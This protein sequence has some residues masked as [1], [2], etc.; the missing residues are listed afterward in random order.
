MKLPKQQH[1]YSNVEVRG[2]RRSTTLRAMI[3]SGAS[4]TFINS[5]IVQLHHI[6]KE[7]LEET[8]V[9]HNIDQT[10]NAGG[11][12]TH[13]APLTLI[14][15][16]HLERIQFLMA[17]IGNDDIILGIDWLDKHNPDI[18]WRKRTIEFRRCNCHRKGV[19]S[20]I[21]LVPD[22]PM[23]IETRCP[24]ADTIIVAAVKNFAQQFADKA[25]EGKKEKTYEELVPTWIR[26]Y[27]DVFSD[28]NATRLPEHTL[29]DHEINLREGFKPRTGK[30]TL[31]LQN[32]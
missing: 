32:R 23:D 26:D 11:Y 13:Y 9:L 24:R 28:E 4:G 20:K 19:V 8:I 27:D 31:S 18:D 14:V 1:F 7:K 29:W 6:R 2:V 16:G 25:L 22:P 3:D 21:E 10:E 5:K 30:I 12:V 15:G 17:N